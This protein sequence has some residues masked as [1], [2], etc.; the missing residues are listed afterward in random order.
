MGG[1]ATRL[2]KAA[3][4]GGDHHRP[5]EGA[6]PGT[7]FEANY[8]NFRKTTAE[9]AV[10]KKRRGPA[11]KKRTSGEK[12][13]EEAR[14]KHRS[15]EF[16]NTKDDEAHPGKESGTRRHETM[17]KT[18]KR[19]GLFGTLFQHHSPKEKAATETK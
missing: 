5:G 9:V 15:K 13:G 19:Q 12:K 4:V 18:P 11:V 3:A 6:S 1:A 16:Q 14:R 8:P 17:E 2:K 10:K 7:I